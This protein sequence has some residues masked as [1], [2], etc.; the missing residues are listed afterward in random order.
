MTNIRYDEFKMQT[1]EVSSLRILRKVCENYEFSANTERNKT[2]LMTVPM[3]I[4]QFNS[5]MK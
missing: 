2:N 3:S 4:G 1:Q 5:K